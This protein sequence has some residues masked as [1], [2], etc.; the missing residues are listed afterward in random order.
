MVDKLASII[1]E[2]FDLKSKTGAKFMIIPLFTE[3]PV[4]F[5]WLILSDNINTPY[6]IFVSLWVL[7]CLMCV[8]YSTYYETKV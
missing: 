6:S 7:I 5:S 2:I 3:I 8:F 1:Q 4:I